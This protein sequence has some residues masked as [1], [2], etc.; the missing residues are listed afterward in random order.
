MQSLPH[1]MPPGV[2]A[3]EPFPLFVTV[4]TNDVAGA[5]TLKTTLFEV[6]A[7]VITVTFAV[8]GEAMSVAGI[9]A[10]S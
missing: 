4:R 7:G 1:A 2:L 3:T 8:P 6:P 5:V 10:V 9:A